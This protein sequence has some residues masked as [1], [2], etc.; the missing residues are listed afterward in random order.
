MYSNMFS[1]R[2]NLEWVADA[3]LV[4]VLTQLP[5][6]LR[7]YCLGLRRRDAGN[8]EFTQNTIHRP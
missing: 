6:V 2:L 8:Y 7:R 5:I 4:A 1:G 3:C